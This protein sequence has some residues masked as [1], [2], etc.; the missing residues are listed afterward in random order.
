MKRDLFNHGNNWK[1]WKENLTDNYIEEG[2][3][4]ENSKLFVQY[5][6]DLE[7][8]ANIPKNSRKGGRDPK[9][10]NRLRSK[11]SCI[12]KILQEAGFN[13]IKKIKETELTEFF[14]KW[15]E[16]GH[17]ADYAKRFKAFWHWWMTVN[18]KQGKLIAD[19][20]E[21]LDTAANGTSQFVWIDK[22]NF[23]KYKKYFDED[24]QVVL[25]F[26]YDTIIRSPTELLSLKVENVF[27]K[28]DEVWIDIPD[29]VSKTF[30][31]KFNLVYCGDMLKK[32]LRD[33][34]LKSTDYLFDFSPQIFNRR[35]QKIAK[36]IFGDKKSEGGEFYKNITMYD[37][38]HSGAIHYRQ[39]FQ[40]TGN[41]LDSLRHRGGWA[42]FKM[43]NYYTKFL[44][45]D[46]HIDKQKT[47]LQ[48]D[49]TKLEKEMEG[50]KELFMKFAK[51]EIVYD[52]E[53]KKFYDGKK[54]IEMKI[55]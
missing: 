41:S 30:G 4:K 11:V 24:E 35:M 18:R 43:I 5:L 38:R 3:T 44:G 47:L 14:A 9:T 22:A 28:D 6:H 50:L 54:P 31:R 52:D 16:K 37:L 13:D 48:E 34:K 17:S 19:V 12:F 36:Q 10:L 7:I 53:E 27:E 8:G 49:K 2:L 20:T 15:R 21:D 42:D 55:I 26:C 23:D 45:L 33:K 1:A 39:L 40:K 46:G 51:G 25:N 32:Y 29:G